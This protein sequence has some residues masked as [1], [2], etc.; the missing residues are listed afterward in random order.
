MSVRTKRLLIGLFVSFQLIVSGLGLINYLNFTNTL[1]L[2][3]KWQ[4][5][6]SQLYNPGYDGTIYKNQTQALA[7]NALNLTAWRGWHEVYLNQAVAWKKLS[8][9]FRPSEGSFLYFIFHRTEQDFSAVRISYAFIYPNALISAKYTGEFIDQKP[10]IIEQL[11]GEGWQEL[12]LKKASSDS[13]EVE[14]WYN[15]ENIATYSTK[16][17]PNGS[18]G[19]R[20]GKNE[21]LVDDV[22]A[23][24]DKGEILLNEKFDNLGHFWEFYLYLI[25]AEIAFNISFWLFLKKRRQLLRPLINFKLGFWILFFF[26]NCFILGFSSILR[27]R[28]PNPNSWFNKLKSQFEYKNADGAAWSQIQNQN[29]FTNYSKAATDSSQ[30][31]IMFI[32]SSQT[33]G[34]GSGLKN[35]NFVS[36]FKN[37][38]DQ[39]PL[40]KTKKFVIINNGKPGTTAS[41]LVEFFKNQWI[42]LKPNVVIINL[43]GNDQEYQTGPDF[44][45]A[46]EEFVDL[47][48]EYNFKLVFLAEANNIEFKPKLATHQTMKEIALKNKL[49]FIDMHKY[50]ASNQNNGILW[51][52]F[53][54]PTSYG[55]KLIAK[56]LFDQLKTKL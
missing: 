56:Q 3:S 30:T 17:D 19:F 25:L 10:L 5:T 35:E 20:A 54:H 26:I 24:G 39:S 31:K 43:S 27:A 8:I 45:T 16:T 15:N 50:L 34:E 55:Y 23:Y 7:Y 46:L 1:A 42:K 29:L 14:V 53:I 11:N 13:Q 40:L 48:R 36:Q 22:V 4:V 38:L 28:Y 47:S 41:Q 51:W 21:I 6:K 44:A 33:E 49:T 52:D 37:L 2:N 9:K 12:T 18:I 32:G